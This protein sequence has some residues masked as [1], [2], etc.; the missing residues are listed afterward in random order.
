LIVEGGWYEQ[1]TSAATFHAHLAAKLRKLGFVPTKADLDLWIRKTKDGTYE[2][3]AFYADDIIV[4]TKDPMKMELIPTFQNLPQDVVYLSPSSLIEQW[5]LC[6]TILSV[7]KRHKYSSHSVV[8]LPGEQRR[9]T[10][11]RK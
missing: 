11:W 4:I 10:R 1:K 7:S 2:Y 5:L 9:L 3:I 6:P 8:N